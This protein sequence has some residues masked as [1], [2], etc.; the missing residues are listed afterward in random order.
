MVRGW[1]AA[2]PNA[3]PPNGAEASFGAVLNTI[4]EAASLDPR[5]RPEEDEQLAFDFDQ[6]ARRR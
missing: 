6:G 5:E 4:G 3:K 2:R 1:S